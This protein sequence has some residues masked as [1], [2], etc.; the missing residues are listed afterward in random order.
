MRNDQ[1]REPDPKALATPPIR[2]AFALLHQDG[3]ELTGLPLHERRTRLEKV[4]QR[5]WTVGED[6]WARR[7]SAQA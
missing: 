1:V 3:R 4:K 7:L 5:D 2:M 6:R